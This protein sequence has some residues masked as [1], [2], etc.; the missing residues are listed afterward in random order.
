MFVIIV[1][2]LYFFIRPFREF[3][4]SFRTFRNEISLGLMDF[5]GIAIL[6]ALIIVY[7]HSL[8]KDA[9]EYA[10]QDPLIKHE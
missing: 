1:N 5:V 4:V 8:R 10:K 9:Q 6:I 7:L 2:T 3:S